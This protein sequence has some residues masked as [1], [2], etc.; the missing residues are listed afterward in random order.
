M[1]FTLRPFSMSDLDDLVKHADNFNIAKN[2]TDKFPHPYSAE[3][4]LAFIEMTQS[5][6]PVSVFAIAVDGKVAGGIGLHPQGDIQ[7]L[8][9]ELGYWVAEP[10]WGHGIATRAIAQIVD[11]GFKNLEINRIFARPFGSNL[12]SQRV[13]EK[14][15]FKFEARFEKTLIKNGAFEDELFYAVRK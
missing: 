8:N 10:F 5:M 11:F 9:A 4:G 15:G 14:A 3:N 7:R 13:L 12:A 2:L 6:R 1:E